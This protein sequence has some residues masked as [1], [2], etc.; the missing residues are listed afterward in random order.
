MSGALF[1]FPES[2][3]Q[4][5]QGRNKMRLIRNHVFVP[6]AVLAVLAICNAAAACTVEVKILKDIRVKGFHG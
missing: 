1:L 2:Y 3:T 6:L 5:K 4:N